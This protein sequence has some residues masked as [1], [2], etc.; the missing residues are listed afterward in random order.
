MNE[1]RPIQPNQSGWKKLISKRWMYPVLYISLAGGMLVL[2]WLYQAR[3]VDEQQQAVIT[4]QGAT[5]AQS[6]TAISD[7]NGERDQQAALQVTKSAETMILPYDQDVQVQVVMPY[8]DRTAPAEVRQKALIKHEQ[9]YMPHSGVDFARKDQQPFVVKSVLSGT[10]SRAE[11]HPLLGNVIEIKHE[12]NLVSVYQSLVKLD[13][14]VNQ[15]IK[16]GDPIGQTGRNEL[17]KDRGV[18]V[19]FELRQNGQSVNPHDWI[20]AVKP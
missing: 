5:D 1:Q 18:H 13:V 11:K 7:K 17:E 12:N 10:V 9:T 2:M 14:S 15:Q 20:P 8:Y 4:S 3:M 19:H 6:Q 16:Q